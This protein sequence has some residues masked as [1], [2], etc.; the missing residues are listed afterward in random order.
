MFYVIVLVAGKIAAFW[1]AR[2]R[3]HAGEIALKAV[4]L[5]CDERGAPQ[6]RPD[7]RNEILAAARK[8]LTTPDNIGVY[9]N[10]WNCPNPPGTPITYT[11]PAP[12]S[13]H[14]M[15]PEFVPSSALPMEIAL[16]DDDKYL[17]NELMQAQLSAC[18][19]TLA[20]HGS[21]GRNLNLQI[22][23]GD[24]GNLLLT[25]AGLLTQSGHPDAEDTDDLPTCPHCGRDLNNDDSVGGESQGCDFCQ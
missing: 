1:A 16:P 4:T 9:R 8:R 24:V 21:A 22:P 6:M 17:D 14:I 11:G 12:F 23:A 3:K 13:V 7:V 15:Q 5:A 20:R 18:A 19:A 2:D 25:V 10:D